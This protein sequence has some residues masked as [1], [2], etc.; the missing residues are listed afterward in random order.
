MKCEKCDKEATFHYQSNINGE[1]TE[2]H[3]CEDCAKAEG[4][5]NV[6]ARPRAM[7]G[8]F[9]REPFGGMMDSFFREPFG[10]LTDSFF[11]RGFFAPV[12]GAHAESTVA[13]NRVAETEKAT[14][15]EQVRSDNIP[16]DAGDE[17]RRKRELL[18]LREQLWS[19]VK[20]EE[21]EKAA[22]LRDKIRELEK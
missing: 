6:F 13:E 8:S 3:L 19:A 5:D 20:T 7:M 17:I 4:L 21:F 2:A 18:L 15:T 11:G 14:E 9:F 22:E 1:K 16:E 10:M 12:L